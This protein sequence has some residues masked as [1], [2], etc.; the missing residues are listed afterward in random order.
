MIIDLMHKTMVAKW[1]A[2]GQGDK[3]IEVLWNEYVP[4]HLLPRL[5]GYELLMAP[6]AIAHVKIGLKLYETGYRFGSDER[7]RIYLTNA[8]EPAS[9]ARQLRLEG[10]LPALAHEAQAVNEIKRKQRFTVVIGNPP[11]SV[12]SYNNS[13][14]IHRLLEDFKKDLNETKINLDDDYI[15]FLRLA[16][17]LADSC[18]AGVVS[19][20][21]NNGF[22]SGVTHRRVRRYLLD[23]FSSICVTN[24][25]GDSRYGEVPPEG[26]KN[27]N[28]F[29]IQQGVCISLF[30]R[31]FA[32]PLAPFLYVDI[33]GSRDEKYARMLSPRTIT[34]E[35]VETIPPLWSFLPTSSEATAE[36]E[37]WPLLTEW[38]PLSSNGVETHKDGLTVQFTPREL[39]DVIDQL[40]SLPVERSRA[41]LNIGD[42]GRDW[43]LAS[44]VSS[45]K[46]MVNLGQKQ[47]TRSHTG[48][49]TCDTQCSM[50]NRAAF[51]RI[52]AGT[53]CPISSIFVETLASSPQ[54]SWR[55]EVAGTRALRPDIQQ[56]RRP[57]TARVVAPFFRF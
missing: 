31:S 14:W 5:H 55:E 8:L 52:R 23:A 9:D 32:A 56:R 19:M 39:N 16:V 12:K 49:S 27:E 57:A 46:A 42:D 29:D 21:T 24:L 26:F 54:D 37:D 48:R 6:Y 13:P 44:A 3:K 28:V 22:L 33:W 20:I 47:C 4:K 1:K 2:Q 43:S 18:R 38:M 53:S 7:A 15:K 40:Q 41:V 30:A 51:L 34:R 45:L 17:Y 10:I 25:H 35:P 36:Y 11:Y 50:R